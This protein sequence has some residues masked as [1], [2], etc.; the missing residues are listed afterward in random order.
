MPRPRRGLKKKVADDADNNDI[1]IKCDKSEQTD[2]I[3]LDYVKFD[4]NSNDMTDKSATDLIEISEVSKVVKNSDSSTNSDLKYQSSI[5][6]LENNPSSKYNNRFQVPEVISQF[7]VYT[8]LLG[9]EYQ[10]QSNSLENI[11]D[12]I[13]CANEIGRELKC[14]TEKPLI[15]I[16]DFS[17]VQSENSK[18]VYSDKNH[19]DNSIKKISKLKD[20]LS[21][22]GAKCNEF[23]RKNTFEANE[24]VDESENFVSTF[25]DNTKSSNKKIDA[26]S[27]K[28]SFTKTKFYST[29]LL[30]GKE[31]VLFIQGTILGVTLTI[32][33]ILVGIFL[34][35]DEDIL[36]S[37]N[38]F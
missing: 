34:K 10:K 38:Y 31:K 9:S 14:L 21:S 30:I 26:S 15:G 3:I 24:K 23:K 22:L 4:G 36:G 18:S 5:E 28:F 27:G 8:K 32:I 29:A 12:A 7:A 20:M 37:F 6:K 25:Q 19:N 1:Q 13:V 11:V 33:S 35:N 16:D 17:S 2:R